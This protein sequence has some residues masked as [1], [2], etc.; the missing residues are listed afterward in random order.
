MIEGHHIAANVF[1]R[2]LALKAVDLDMVEGVPGLGDKTVLH[3]FL[4]AGKVDLGGGVRSAQG[5]RNGKGRVDMA[6]GA[7]GGDENAHFKQ[8]LNGYT[9]LRR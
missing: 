4:P 9:G 7:A 3:A 5:A 8:L 1:G 2:Q 6:G